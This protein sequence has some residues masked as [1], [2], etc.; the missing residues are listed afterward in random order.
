MYSGWL[1]VCGDLQGTPQA[2]QVRTPLAKPREL[3]PL[4][5]ERWRLL[6]I[7]R[8]QQDA[9]STITATMGRAVVLG[10]YVLDLEDAVDL[11]DA[12]SDGD[13][14]GVNGIQN[15]R[16]MLLF[17]MRQVAR[18]HQDQRLQDAN[19]ASENA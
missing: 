12:E 10:D 5:E 2:C 11:E 3:D 19:G 7:A 4:L 8:E 17:I 15:T 18:H 1:L 6:E 16:R 9:L 14:D 13:V